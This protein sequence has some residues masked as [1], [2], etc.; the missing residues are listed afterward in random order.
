[1]PPA[2]TVD[3]KIHFYK[4]RVEHRSSTPEA[5]V[6]I[7]DAKNACDAVAQL[8]FVSG[9]RYLTFGDGDALAVWPKQSGSRPHLIIG[10]LRSS[11]LPELE[12]G[13][14]FR[15][16]EVAEKEKVAEKTHVVF[17]ENN[18]VGAEFNFYGPRLTK[19]SYYLQAKG[20]ASVAF[21]PLL[22]RDVQEELEHLQD[23]RI[24]QL[25]MRREELGLLKEAR[26]SLP[27]A[28][29]GWSE[30][31]DAPVIEVSLRQTPRSRK[32][33]GPKLMEFVRTL[34][35]LPQTTEGVGIFKVHGKDDRTNQ[36]RWFDLL[37][38]KFVAVRKVVKEGTKHRVINS[39]S[40][41][42]E[43]EAAYQDLRPQLERATSISQ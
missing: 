4:A 9:E 24:L 2:N 36:V 43:I 33:M 20:I 28:L 37:E 15:R 22:N 12:E 32:G 8:K 3:K 38:D 27:D 17:F 41:F 5:A 34:A 7:F 13:G 40:M 10:S 25:R 16:L 39:E 11:G 14:Q 19:L 23:I 42:A 29:R 31:V 6:A 26:E 18:I 35:G 30:S 21:D 1:M